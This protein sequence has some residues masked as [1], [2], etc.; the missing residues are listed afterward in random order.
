LKIFNSR[1]D[2]AARIT[3]A[4]CWLHNYCEGICQNQEVLEGL[5]QTH[6]W[7]LENLDFLYLEKESMQ[8]LKVRHLERKCTKSG[9]LRI[10][11]I[12]GRIL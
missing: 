5:V 2:K 10:L 3:V 4:C 8:K 12:S 7:D 6:L 11:L 9:W 1:V